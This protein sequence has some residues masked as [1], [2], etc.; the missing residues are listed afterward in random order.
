MESLLRW[1]LLIIAVF[2]V[3][4]IVYDVWFRR[5]HRSRHKE[6]TIQ[7]DGIFEPFLPSDKK[8]YQVDIE[9][10]LSLNQPI[11]TIN[12]DTVSSRQSSRADDIIIISVLAKPAAHFA[13]YDLFQAISATG[14]QYGE[15]DIFHY[16]QSTNQGQITLF[17]LASATKPGKFNLD[18]MGDF[19]C[20]G[21]SLFMDKTA[22]PNPKQA[23]LLM[24]EKAEQLAD[25]LDGELRVGPSRKPW[26]N[27]ILQSYLSSM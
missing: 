18:R 10:S 2:I 1:G 25:D 7:N 15:M 4:L 12:Q 9:P 24:L 3:S 16:Y 27:E 20:V 23:F 11:L 22:S 21:L 26:N 19:S 8:D 13:S 17:S 14:M 6:E 5:S